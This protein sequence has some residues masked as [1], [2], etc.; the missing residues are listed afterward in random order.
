VII[1]TVSSHLRHPVD[2][3]IITVSSHLR[4]RRSFRVLMML[5]SDMR[6]KAICLIAAECRSPAKE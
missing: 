2:V 4:L 1:I 5:S 3:M 6:S